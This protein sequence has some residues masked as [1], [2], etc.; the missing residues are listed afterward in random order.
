MAA[1]S[2]TQAMQ[3][4]PGAS[5]QGV[6]RREAGVKEG[7]FHGDRRTSSEGTGIGIGLTACQRVVA[8]VVH[9]VVND[10]EDWRGAVVEGDA[11]GKVAAGGDEIGGAV[12]GI[13]KPGEPAHGVV[14]L[15]FGKEGGLR[16]NLP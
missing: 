13:D 10:A 14:F 16:C 5:A 3:R 9:N 8:D 12:D 11:D 7:I 15:L 1:H 2:A 4:F 6:H